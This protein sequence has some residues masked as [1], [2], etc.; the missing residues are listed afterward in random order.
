[1]LRKLIS[2]IWI[3]GTM[4]I[5]ASADSVI[6]IWQTQ[7][8]DGHVHIQPCGADRFCGTLVWFDP[9]SPTGPI[10]RQ[11]P[12]PTLRNRDLTGTEILS[13]VPATANSGASGTI[14]NPHDGNSFD[15]R[16]ALQSSQTLRVTGCWGVICRSNIW[17]RVSQ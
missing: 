1:M 12:N 4:P 14:Y 17:H 2:A 10:D 9:Q 5:S 15:A 13:D 8:R 16:I 11:N 3:A 6:G 7:D